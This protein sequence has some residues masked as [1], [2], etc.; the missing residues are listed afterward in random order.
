VSAP[1]LDPRATFEDVHAAVSPGLPDHSAAMAA[2]SGP[3]NLP[4]VPT[5]HSKHVGGDGAGYPS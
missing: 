2:P 4:E 5:A 1:E 3:V